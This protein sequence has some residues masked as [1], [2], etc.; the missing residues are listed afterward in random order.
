MIVSLAVAVLLGLVSAQ[1][2]TATATPASQWTAA[3]GVPSYASPAAQAK[4]NEKFASQFG[5]NTTSFGGWSA[6][7]AGAA[8]IPSAFSPENYL[9]QVTGGAGVWPGAGAQTATPLAMVAVA[10]D[11]ATP[12]TP[13]VDPLLQAKLDQLQLTYDRRALQ[14][15]QAYELAE[16]EMEIQ[17][18]AEVTAVQ[19][20]HVAATTATTQAAAVANNL[21]PVA[22]PTP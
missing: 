16:L 19:A 2:T 11:A 6:G 4:V 13:T 22:T 7:T 10:A 9:S 5:I 20:A 15:E 14:M 18:Q 17:R 3:A 8:G 21:A 1:G 12:A